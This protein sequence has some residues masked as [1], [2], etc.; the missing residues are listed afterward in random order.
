MKDGQ[1]FRLNFEQKYHNV[2]K[3]FVL[4]HGNHGM[5]LFVQLIR[6][7]LHSDPPLNSEGG[8]NVVSP[9]D[10]LEEAGLVSNIGKSP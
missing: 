1:A 8:G 6:V 4:I 5:M 10:L 3:P 9:I 2:Q 7:D